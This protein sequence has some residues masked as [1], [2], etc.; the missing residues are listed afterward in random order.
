MV[1]DERDLLYYFC[2]KSW[3][4]LKLHGFRELDLT[5]AISWEKKPYIFWYDM[6]WY[7]QHFGENSIFFLVEKK[8]RILRIM[9]YLH[10]NLLQ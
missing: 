5:D 2:G 4:L 3:F 1:S 7:E 9:T 6:N 8:T 10:N